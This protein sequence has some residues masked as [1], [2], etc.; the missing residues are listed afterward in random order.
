M[1]QILAKVV[2]LILFPSIYYIVKKLS[3]KRFFGMK[4]KKIIRFHFLF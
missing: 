4:D 1:A 3:Q 2:A